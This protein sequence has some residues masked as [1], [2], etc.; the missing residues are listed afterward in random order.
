MSKKL[1]VVV[2]Y[3]VKSESVDQYEH[4]MKSII[5]I[6]PNYGFKKIEW[7]SCSDDN[8][9]YVEIYEVP[10][11]SHYYALKKLRNNMHSNSMFSSL[12]IFLNGKINYWV[13][14]KAS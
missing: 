9:R 11:E 7:F 8:H 12:K 13:I 10:S 3:S 2:E 6:L 5:H 14:K 4:L 1:K